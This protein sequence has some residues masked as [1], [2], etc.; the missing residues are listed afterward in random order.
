MSFFGQAP[1]NP[2]STNKPAGSTMFGSTPSSGGGLF[3]TTA[4]TT[5]T[6]SFGAG[7]F[8]GGFGGSAATTASNP[9]GATSTGF[10]AQPTTTAAPFGTSFGAQPAQTSSPFG[11]GGFGAQPAQTSNPF[12]AQPTTAAAPFG[13]GFGAGST[14]STFGAQPTQASSPF[15][16]G[17]GAQPT[18][19]AS[20]PFGFGSTAT[21]GT[22]LGAQPT[23]QT[24]SPFG[25]TSFGAQ[26]TQASISPFGQQQGFNSGGQ[27]NGVK[28]VGT[29]NPPY[30][31]TSE[32]GVNLVSINAMEAYNGK[33]VEELRFEDYTKKEQTG[34]MG[35]GAGAISPFGSTLGQP[36]A[37]SSPFG[38]T[39]GQPAPAQ[40]SNMFGAPTTQS[41][42]FGSTTT[43]Q[44]SSNPFG[45]LGS[46]GNPSATSSP[47]GSLGGLGQQ[48]QQ[49]P[50]TQFNMTATQSNPFGASS[51]PTPF[52]Q[53]S[54]LLTSGFPSTTSQPT[55]GGGLF[56]AVTQ[57]QPSSGGG[58][59]G[60][61]TA[62][63]STPGGGLFGTQPATS[64]GGLFGQQQTTPQ[65]TTG[66][67]LFGPTSTTGGGLFGQPTSQPASG[68]GGL[69]GTTTQQQQPS[70]GGGLFGNPQQTT[71]TSTL[72]STPSTSSTATP[73]LGLFGQ[74]AQST[75]GGLFSQP[76]QP[77]TGG[78]FSQPAQPSTGGLFSQPA[79]P[80]TGGGLFGNQPTASSGVPSLG[81]GLF[82]GMGSSATPSLSLGTPSMTSGGMFGQQQ[83]SLT[84]TMPTNGGL[85]GSMQPTA[86][87]IQTTSVAQVAPIQI[88]NDSISSQSPYF[89]V[90]A[91]PFVQLV[92]SIKSVDSSPSTTGADSSASSSVAQLGRSTLS[93]HSYSGRPKLVPRRNAGFDFPTNQP[94]DSAVL[95]NQPSTTS[96]LNNKPVSTLE[97]FVSKYSKTLNVNTSGETLQSLMPTQPKLYPTLD[98][99]QQSSILSSSNNNQSN[100]NNNNQ[101]SSQ[102]PTQQQQQQV[103]QQQPIQQQPAQQQQVQQQQQQPIQTSPKKSVTFINPHAPIL[104]KP[105]YYCRPSLRELES[106]TESELASVREFTIER[107]GYGSVMFLGSTDV[108]DLNIDEI[109]TI[110]VREVSIY[111]D[112]ETKPPVG[113]GLNKRSMVTLQQCWPK[114]SD[115]SYRKSENYLARYKNALQRKAAEE[116]F[117][118][119]EYDGV[120][121]EW[122]FKVEHFSKYSAPDD[123]FEDE[124]GEGEQQVQQQPQQQLISPQQPIISSK[125]KPKFSANISLDNDN[126]TEITGLPSKYMKI[127]NQKRILN[128]NKGLF[129]VDVPSNQ[130]Q[131]APIQQ[132]KIPVYD[133]LVLNNPNTKVQRIL[134]PINP[135]F[136]QI[137]LQSPKSTILK[138]SHFN[139]RQ[140]QSQEQPFKKAQ[141]LE[142][143]SAA[144]IKLDSKQFDVKVASKDSIFKGLVNNGQKTDASLILGRSFRVGWSPNGQFIVPSG[145]SIKT[146][147][148]SN[149]TTQSTTKVE[150]IVK[151]LKNHLTNSSVCSKDNR[152]GWFTLSKVQEQLQA[153]SNDDHYKHIWKLIVSLWG[154]EPETAYSEEMKRKLNL[155]Q[156]L[157]DVIAPIAEK[158]Q[159]QIKKKA[160]H[161][162]LEVLFSNLSAKKLKES[163][164]LAN[165]NKD[166]R[167]AI[168]MTQLWGSNESKILLTEQ[169]RLW[170]E[171]G[172]LEKMD[173]KR[174]EIIKLLAGD[175]DEVYQNVNDWYR[176][177]A[178]DFWFR[179]SFDHPLSEVIKSYDISFL[180]GISKSPLPTYTNINSNEDNLFF[181]PCYLLLKLFS[182]ERFDNFKALF[183]PENN[184]LDHFDYWLPWSLYTVL[185]SLP[186]LNKQS[187]LSNQ[188]LLHSSFA[189]QL[190]R[191]GL[192]QWSIYI[193]SHIPDHFTF[194]RE[195]AMKSCISRHIHTIKEDGDE[196]KFLTKSLLIPETWIDEAFA[197]YN[198]YQHK[199][200][201][202][203]DYLLKSGQFSEAHNLIFNHFGPNYIISRKYDKLR[204]L[205]KKFQGHIN[206]IGLWKFG[207]EL[208]L[209]YIML[210]TNFKEC[211][212]AL[213]TLPKSLD[214]KAIHQKLYKTT[215][216][217]SL[218][219]AHLSEL[220]QVSIIENST[221]L[222]KITLSEMTKRLLEYCQETNELFELD[223]IRLNVLPIGFVRSL[224]KLPITED[225]R[226]CSLESLSQQCQNNIL[227]SIY[228]NIN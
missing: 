125:P 29:G 7:G 80:S 81:G 169:L 168:M 59:F 175:I 99:P 192:W 64:G 152:Q 225:Q 65:S 146:L 106:M 120:S 12:G 97:K 25:T 223:R 105:G 96:Y 44:Q 193:L 141:Q 16:G 87:T 197:W 209:N 17:F 181:D 57:Q 54:S 116:Q 185:R 89:P 165:A 6:S 199:E 133:P 224:S 76:T 149:I 156:W 130:S 100:I 24:S 227:D 207:G 220:S 134:S 55:S 45:G 150:P 69:F 148:I 184:G 110:D 219:L 189:T 131:I 20:S 205:L 28:P 47:F 73:S 159:Q 77:S 157:K 26:P 145:K 98:N 62:Q 200:Q 158:E 31:E 208:F 104:T 53:S 201:N 214:P 166:Y 74:P 190:E 222:F 174:I 71:P 4:P 135:T 198:G 215:L 75:S 3:G 179:Y 228:A 72:F 86:G 153:Y 115:G 67:G 94:S 160:N 70:S 143:S 118:F 211:F 113:Q 8:G 30:K 93:Y 154:T 5:T 140:V 83:P 186:S 85:F 63:T 102:Q 88:T 103:Q 121:G 91:S 9:F 188:Y 15:G 2:F 95:A 109:V 19:Q 107:K 11:S 60:Q 139:T 50:T 212:G 136:E 191:L 177:F 122:R 202:Q 35:G 164:A 14:T 213:E 216:D 111:P 147:T 203:I 58:L 180:N 66:G 46:L 176:S 79:Q 142:S 68:G 43:T 114:A 129:N 161:N 34:S 10:G 18:Q 196:K 195:E 1:S 82:G 123:E 128:E 187:D 221:K 56:G 178:L 37:S 21:S 127:P 163:I 27:F 151:S 13:G 162:Y 23:Q 41:N 84:A 210:V 61:P 226:L 108:R 32:G 124:D 218:F 39:L 167:L 52:G 182:N 132:P 126:E 92:K 78:L 112:E 49:Q 194:F 170:E 155:N 33:S 40:Q 171:Q 101:S 206:D 173:V 36:S 119:I 137:N 117:T 22:L 172:M 183:Y 138:P 204:D 90:P 48:Q 144:K 217:S 38:S 51:T 42:P